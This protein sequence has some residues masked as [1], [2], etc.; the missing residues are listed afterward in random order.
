[1]ELNREFYRAMYRLNNTSD[2]QLFKQYLKDSLNNTFNEML[3]KKDSALY[4]LQGEASKIKELLD[5]FDNAAESI[6]R[7]DSQDTFAMDAKNIY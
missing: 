4:N 1:M 6:N 5:L 2:G 7:L 3:Y